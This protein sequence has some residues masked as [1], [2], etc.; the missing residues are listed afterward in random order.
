MPMTKDEALAAIDWH[1]PYSQADA[2]SIKKVAL[3]LR[4][5]ISGDFIGDVSSAE[6]LVLDGVTPG[7]AAASK[8]AVLGASKELAGMLFRETINPD[9]AGAGS[10][11]SD[12]AALL[13]GF[14][15]ITGANGTLGWRLPTAVAGM[16]VTIKG[17][18]AGVAKIW[19]A[20]G[21]QINAVGADTAMSLASGVIPA[22]FIAKTATQWYTIPLLP[23]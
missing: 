22:I 3:V 6:L 5:L 7:T 2:G 16:R 18:T 12:A 4:A 21:A 13:E 11:Q 8:A 9:V 20:T 15:V 19:P 14:Q 10:I 1:G 23:S 17:T